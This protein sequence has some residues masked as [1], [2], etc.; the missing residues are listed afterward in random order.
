[1]TLMRIMR[2]S[3]AKAHLIDACLLVDDPGIVDESI[4]TAECLIH[5]AKHGEHVGL[6]AD[7]TPDG[8]RLAASGLDL[9]H[10]L[11]RRRLVRGIVHRNAVTGHGA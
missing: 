1:M 2:S 11:V 10:D 6:A 3:R 5:R 9:R 7:I 4:E 8:N